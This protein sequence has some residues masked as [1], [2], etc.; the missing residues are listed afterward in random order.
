MTDSPT[1]TA[2]AWMGDGRR[3]RHAERND[4][5][6]HEK[7]THEVLRQTWNRPEP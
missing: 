6:R 4:A 5:D 1:T 7:L 3:R 2:A